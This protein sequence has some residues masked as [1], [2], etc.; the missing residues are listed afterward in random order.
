VIS[1]VLVVRIGA[2]EGRTG[3]WWIDL[4]E[5]DLGI[6]GNIILKYIINKLDG[7][8][9]TGLLWLRVGIFGGRL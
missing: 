2:G 6:D 1:A 8:V 3:F 7:E 5:R 4:I 9:L